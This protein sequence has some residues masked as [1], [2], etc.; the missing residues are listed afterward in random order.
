[1]CLVWCFV[2]WGLI[3]RARSPTSTV[4]GRPGLPRHRPAGAIRS[5]TVMR[6]GSCANFVMGLPRVKEYALAEQGEACAAEIEGSHVIM[7]SQPDAVT[8]VILTALQS[9]S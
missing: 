8:E 9:V 4:P 6:C 5:V 7:I 2:P 1:M 3:I